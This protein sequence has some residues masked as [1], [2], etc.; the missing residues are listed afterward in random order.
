[1]WVPMYEWML[2]NNFSDDNATNVAFSST[3]YL[4]SF[5]FKIM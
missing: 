2:E 4:F 1:M 5:V 3:V